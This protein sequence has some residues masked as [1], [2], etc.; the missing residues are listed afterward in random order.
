MKPLKNLLWVLL[1]I[2]TLFYN[3]DTA[4][5]QS[6]RKLYIAMADLSPAIK[7]CMS[8]NGITAIPVIYSKEVDPDNQMKVNEQSFTNAVQQKIPDASYSG[9]A[10]VDWEG[11]ILTNLIFSPVNTS[12]YQDALSEYL[13]LLNL[14]KQLRPNAKWGLFPIPY[15]PPADKSKLKFINPVTDLLK[16][17]DVFFPQLYVSFNDRS[18]S[19]RR[20]NPEK[21][22]WVV[23]NIQSILATAKALNKPVLPFI[24]HRFY[25]TGSEFKGN[26]LK[27]IPLDEFNTYIDKIMSIDYQGKKVDGLVWWGNDSYFFKAKSQAMTDEFNNNHRG[28]NFANYHDSLLTKYISKINKTVKSK[29]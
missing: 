20:S 3:A 24:W 7:S 9:Y 12:Q 28:G 19:G 6:N 25:G 5:A 23:D 16:A 14:A 1:A 17:C 10:A 26:N 2:G 4:S 29:N 11:K 22:Q 21:D 8:Q 13:K 18:D 27:L 15:P